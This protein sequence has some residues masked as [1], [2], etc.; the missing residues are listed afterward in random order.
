M[1]QTDFAPMF[2]VAHAVWWPFASAEEAEAL[3]KAEAVSQYGFYNTLELADGEESFGKT[4]IRLTAQNVYRLYVNDYFVMHGPARTAHGYA[5]VDEIDI[6][7]YL[8]EGVNHIA[9]EVMAYG[10]CYGQYS[11]DCTMEAG[12]FTCEIDMDE[13]TVLAT[14]RDEWK[15]CKLP[16]RAPRTDR[17]SHSREAAEVYYLDDDYFLWRLGLVSYVT[18]VPTK[19]L[20]YLP[21]EALMPTLEKHSYTTLVSSGACRIDREMEVPQLFYLKWSP[22]YNKSFDEHPL[23]D[24]R[25][26]KDVF[27]PNTGRVVRTEDGLCIQGADG[28]T[29]RYVM[30]DSGESFVGFIG[31]RL[32]AEKAG[33]VDIVHSEMLSPEGDIPYAHNI[34]TRLHVQAGETEFVT[35]EASIA[36]YLKVFFR[37]TGDVVLQDLYLLDDSY[38][39]EH[40]SG[41]QCS[42]ENITRL[43]NAA[44]K[45]LI[46]NT[47]DIFMDC[48]E[49]ERGGWLCDSFWT[50]RAAALMLSDHRVE[51]EFIENFLLTD[52]EKIFHGFFPEV[53][54][55]HKG[56]YMP[57]P[58]ITTWSFWLMCEYCEFVRR[59]GDI[60]FRDRF[61]E[62]IEA[63]VKGTKD[64]IGKSNLLQHFPFIYIDGSY[65]NG[66]DYTQP[67]STAANAL[68]AHMMMELGSLY[69]REDWIAE[70]EAIR[71]ILRDVTGNDRS[72]E[73][74]REHIER[75]SDNLNYNEENGMLSQTDKA[76]EGGMCTALWSGLWE[77]GEM[78]SLD[79]MIRD[80]LGPAPFYAPPSTIGRSA[81]FIGF[82]IRLDLLAKWG[83]IDTMLKDMWAVYGPQLR[84]G[85]GTLWEHFEVTNSSRCH[86][87]EGHV[88]VLLMRELLGLNIPDRL[89][90]TIKLTPHVNGLRWARGTHT[91]DTGVVSLEWKYDGDSF[92]LRA[93]IPAGY[94]YELVLPNE[95]KGLDPEKVT[96]EIEMQKAE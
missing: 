29:D 54:P 96:I 65:A 60:E 73:R 13:N 52:P 6:T 7:Q 17:I 92:L 15:M 25:R 37:G 24:C 57:A 2:K 30:F 94:T 34:V 9:V 32:F 88:G 61:R 33:V 78:P 47:M 58:G 26:T 59:T 85:P 44:K 31:I 93:S 41:F 3:K 10:D 22:D 69:G 86:G 76:S 90:R 83:Q 55:A 70:G 81:L 35:M 64:F 66:N 75:F 72:G 38:P 16:Q 28:N 56:S 42:D 14:G 91:T 79:R 95:V 21:H 11:N 71:T 48:P 20:I 5:R 39:D 18:P 12:S 51:K 89:D 68:Y 50:A 53:Y 77:R 80:C 1:K 40:A 46:L 62:R 36:R 87:F 63:F 45:T 23:D 67:I 49:R 4:V 27:A 82:C 8:S 74:L 84:E 19:D 43:Y